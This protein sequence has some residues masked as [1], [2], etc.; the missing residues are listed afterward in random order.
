MFLLVSAVLTF[1][2]ALCPSEQGVMQGTI[3]YL[4]TFLTDLVMMDTAMKDY[5]EVRFFSSC[6]PAQFLLCFGSSLTFIFDLLFQ[7]GLIN[8]EKRRKVNSCSVVWFCCVWKQSVAWMSGPSARRSSRSSLRSNCFSWPPT[9]TVS[10]RTATSEN[11]SQAWRSSAR[12]RGQLICWSWASPLASPHSWL[13]YA[14]KC[15]IIAWF[16]FSSENFSL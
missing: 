15:V 9:T 1:S 11:G 16:G 3:P 10:L 7:G 13:F 6:S 2:S 12:P 5:T 8:F 4:G 14:N